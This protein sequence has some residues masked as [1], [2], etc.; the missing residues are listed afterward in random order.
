[1]SVLLCKQLRQ[2]VCE[3]LASIVRIRSTSSPAVDDNS[4]NEPLEIDDLSMQD[5]SVLNDVNHHHSKTS[6]AASAA[7][8][9][10]AAGQ[11]IS[12]VENLLSSILDVQNA[13]LRND[14]ELHHH[15]HHIQQMMSEW[16]VAAAV[17]DRICF[18]VMAFL[19]ITAT[20]I[21]IAL[22]VFHSEL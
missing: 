20:V 11:S 17:I 2:L 19:F 1:M 6:T 12:S 10:A 5:V 22:L 18:C 21:L 9:A 8:T 15:E 3:R 16:R 13:R 7:A 4:K 14:A